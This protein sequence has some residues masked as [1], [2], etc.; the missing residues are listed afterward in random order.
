MEMKLYL[1]TGQEIDI[2]VVD[3]PLVHKWVEHFCSVPVGETEISRL[4]NRSNFFDKQQFTNLF[5]ELLQGV[6]HY[7]GPQFSIVDYEDYTAIQELMNTMH[8]WCVDLVKSKHMNQNYSDYAFDVGYI[9]R[10]N[11]LCHQCETL[12]PAGTN[13][14]PE[15]CRYIYWDQ[16]LQNDKQHRL[17]LTDEWLDLMTLDK[18]DVYVAKRILGKDYREAYRDNDNPLY[19]EMQPLGDTIPVA[20][21][22]DPLNNW[23]D[24]YNS[25]EFLKY[26]PVAPTRHNI[27]RIPIGNISNSVD[28]IEYVLYNSH[29]V[30][31]SCE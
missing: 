2:A 28:N 6:E 24:L 14:L 21:E 25:P 17:P 19:E 3:N 8:H 7:K 4:D 1:D 12:L 22:F 15:S 27:G 5:E 30:K 26:L 18:Y 13:P 9:G 11:S 29:I 10:L 16:P 23:P 31:A 20:F